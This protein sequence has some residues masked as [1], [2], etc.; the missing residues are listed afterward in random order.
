VCVL[1]LAVITASRK[2]HVFK[3]SVENQIEI[4]STFS[5]LHWIDNTDPDGS[6]FLLKG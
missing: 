3:L 1:V 2:V 4:L 5:D 6:D